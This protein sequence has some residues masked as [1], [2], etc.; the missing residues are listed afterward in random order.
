MLL[1][2]ERCCWG[3]KD[4]AGA[5]KMLMGAQ[6]TQLGLEICGWVVKMGS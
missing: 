2:V 6:N 4:A 1:G 5:R 3:L